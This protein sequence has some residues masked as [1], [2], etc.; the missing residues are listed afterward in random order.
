MKVSPL[1]GK[2]AEAS[3][4]VNVPKLITASYT[5]IPGPSMPEQRVSFATSGHR[6]SAF[7]K[8]FNE[9]HLLAI[10]QAICLYRRQHKLDGPLFLDMDA[11][12]GAKISLGVD[13]LGGAGVHYWGPMAEH[14]GLNLNRHGIVTRSAGLLPPNHYLAVAIF[15]LLPTPT[16]VAH[17]NGGL[18]VVTESGWFAERPSGTEDI[19]KI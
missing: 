13:P 10:S 1:A 11:I 18:K 9:W 6:G 17:G 2:P 4:L 12:R 15:Y 7:K 8:S 3:L 5:E 19:Y 16:E 14:Y